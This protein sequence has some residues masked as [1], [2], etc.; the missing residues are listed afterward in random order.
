MS[1]IIGICNR[2]LTKLGSNRIT[3]LDDN[4]KPARVMSS[5]YEAVRRAEIRAHRWS[6]S[7]TR[8]QLPALAT[9]PAW[10]PPRQFQIPS[11]NLRLDQIEQYYLWWGNSWTGFVG[12]GTFVDNVYSVEGGKILTYLPAPLN[13]RYARDIEDPNMFDATFDESLAC[14]LALEACEDLT[15]SST[16]FQQIS[17]EYEDSLKSAIRCNAIERP[18]EPLAESEWLLARI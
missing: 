9:A 4:T 7:I 18:P 11:D 13:I 15:Q 8:A 1:S 10:G 17:A 3:S 6:F 5:M 12:T 16:K 2:A 14:K